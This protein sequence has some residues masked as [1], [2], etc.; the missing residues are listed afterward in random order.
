MNS[1]AGRTSF[2]ERMIGAAR[3]D[4]HVYEEVEADS[5]ATMQAATVIVLAAVAAGIGALDEGLA[6]LVVGIVTG[7]VGWAAYAFVAY[8][9]GTRW[10]HGKETSAT[11]G[12]VL[13]TLGFANSPRLLLV[14]GIIPILGWIISFAVFV[15]VLVTTVVAIRQALDFSTGSAIATAVVSWLIFVVVSFVITLVVALT[16]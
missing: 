6:P 13:R 7:L 4:V 5:A 9:V 2:V 10:F 16:I 12:E 3:L 11:W 8:W 15:W 14:L 1:V